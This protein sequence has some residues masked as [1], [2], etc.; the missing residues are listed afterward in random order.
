MFG[1]YIVVLGFTKQLKLFESPN[2]LKLLNIAEIYAL[3][4]D[5][6]EGPIIGHPSNVFQ[7]HTLLT[8]LSM[9]SVSVIL[10]PFLKLPQ[11]CP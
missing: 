10:I 8:K 2:R 3:A 1:I 9:K 7:I 5:P 6:P 4:P 11:K